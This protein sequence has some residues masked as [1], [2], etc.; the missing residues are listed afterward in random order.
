MKAMRLHK[1]DGA[2]GL[3]Y[4][5]VPQP[6]PIAGEVLVRVYATGVTPAELGWKT[7]WKT[8]EGIERRRPIPGHELAGMIVQV[9]RDVSDLRV[10]QAVY[11]LTAFD[12]D[13]SLAEYA[14]ALPSELAPL[15]SSLDYVHAAAVPLGA[16]TA[17]QALCDHAGL[18]AGQTLLVHSAASAVGIF[19]VQLARWAKAHVIGVDAPRNQELL[20]ELGCEQVIDLTTTRFEDVVRNVDVV[21]D[22]V[23]LGDALDRSWPLL[24]KGGTLIS[25][26]RQP[27]PK[28]AKA[29]DVRAVFFVVEPNR[30]ELRQIAELID[31]QQLRPVLGKVLPLSEARQAYEQMNRRETPGKIVLQVVGVPS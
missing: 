9:G 27:S 1:Q 4:E 29:Y 10:G 26:A 3:I 15:P 7:T 25:L 12:R 18:A 21:L 17:W 8:R 22:A 6:Q 5:H 23:G 16:L 31:T 24:R 30:D 28:Q 13:G 19:A 2:S 11:G 14:I 20:R